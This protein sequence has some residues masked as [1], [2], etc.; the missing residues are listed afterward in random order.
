VETQAIIK[1]V[2]L[3]N[4]SGGT[5]TVNL[6]LNANGT[7]RRIIPNDLSLG[8]DHLLEADNVYMLEAGDAIEGDSDTADVVDYTISITEET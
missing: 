1:I 2:T 7:S 8:V 4:T 3:V 5:R 6:Y